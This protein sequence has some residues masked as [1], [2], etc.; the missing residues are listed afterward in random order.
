MVERCQNL[1]WIRYKNM[2]TIEGNGMGQW[3]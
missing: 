3:E 1:T 2:V